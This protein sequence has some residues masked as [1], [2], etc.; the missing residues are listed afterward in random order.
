M[1][2]TLMSVLVV[3]VLSSCA[4]SS[5]TAVDGTTELEGCC[6]EAFSLIDQMPGCCKSGISTAGNLTGCCAAG[7]LDETAD[8]DRPDCCA[9]GKALLDQMS[10]CCKDT[11]LTGTPGKCCT[12][13][14]AELAK[15]GS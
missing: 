2:R 4:G 5:E 1:L 8:A 7:L 11:I 14:V 3:A 10:P 15:L 6:K 13:M 12:A 9:E